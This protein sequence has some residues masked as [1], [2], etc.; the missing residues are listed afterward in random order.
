MTVLRMKALSHTGNHVWEIRF[1]MFLKCD[2]EYHITMNRH[3]ELDQ[4]ALPQQR[5][6]LASMH[7]TPVYFP[8]PLYTLLVLNDDITSSHIDL[9]ELMLKLLCL[10]AS[11]VKHGTDYPISR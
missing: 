6:D 2:L 10:H 4:T 11:P 7:E 8:L 1:G 3:L 9:G 5:K